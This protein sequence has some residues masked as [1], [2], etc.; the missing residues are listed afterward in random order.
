MALRASHSLDAYCRYIDIPGVPVADTDECEQFYPDT[1]EP[2]EHH[3]LINTTLEKVEHG[4]IK[5]V[6]LFMPPGSAKST[7]ASVVFPTWFMGRNPS[8]NIISTSYGSDLAKKFG[9]KCRAITRSEAFEKVFNTTLNQD[10]Q[11]VDNWSLTNGATYMAGGIL[12]GITGNRAD[13]LIIDDPVKG[14]EQAESDVFYP[15][16]MKANQAGLKPVM[17][18]NGT[19]S[20]FKHSVNGRMIR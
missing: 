7:Y 19:S 4:E 6:M 5:R 20:V 2:A 16:V 1:V 3:Q 15:W 11:A 13:G 12:S 14:H 8:K 17:V 9:R 18:R 10:N